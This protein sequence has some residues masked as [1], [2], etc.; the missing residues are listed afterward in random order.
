[1]NADEAI[2]SLQKAQHIILIGTPFNDACGV[3]IITGNEP[4]KEIRNL[5]VHSANPEMAMETFQNIAKVMLEKYEAAQT[6]RRELV[7][8]KEKLQQVVDLLGEI[9]AIL[10]PHRVKNAA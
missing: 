3:A 6:L 1:M 4:T 5:A 9:D 8:A 10:H 7:P 2:Q